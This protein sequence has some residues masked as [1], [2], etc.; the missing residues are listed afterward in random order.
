MYVTEMNKPAMTRLLPILMFACGL[1]TISGC[2][3]SPYSPP[4]STPDV[5]VSF[6]LT[7][8]TG[9]VVTAEA[10]G[11][12]L[13][14]V[15]FGFASCPHICPVTL[16]NIA[17]ALNSL[18]THAEDITVLFISVDPKRDTPEVLQQYTDAFHPSIIGF[19]GTYDQLSAVTSGFRAAFGYNAVSDDGQERPLSRDQYE[20]LPPEVSYSPYHSSQIYVI[21][22]NN[23]LLDII[24][25][26]SKPSLIEEKLRAYLN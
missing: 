16:Q 13:R 20:S 8:E 1:L 6:E 19:T 12:K 4:A 10:F 11:G 14:L 3:K 24:G 25:Y 5:N 7:D 17:I 18:G 22:A 9:N 23:E 26:G 21:G 2:Q 15:F